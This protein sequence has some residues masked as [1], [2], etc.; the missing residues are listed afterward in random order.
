MGDE[1]P[2]ALV[3]DEREKPPFGQDAEQHCRDS[4]NDGEAI[5]FASRERATSQTECR[6]GQQQSIKAL[7]R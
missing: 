1:V 4:A 7:V 2:Q 3:A 5:R 6:T